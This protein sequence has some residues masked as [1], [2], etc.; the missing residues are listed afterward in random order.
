MTESDVEDNTLD[1]VTETQKTK[2]SLLLVGKQIHT[3]VLKNLPKQLVQ[4]ISWEDLCL[5]L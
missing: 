1:S 4:I 5:V 3:K 2:K